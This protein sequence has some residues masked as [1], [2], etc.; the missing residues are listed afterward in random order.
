MGC[1]WP[2]LISGL[3]LDPVTASKHSRISL[4]IHQQ[5]SSR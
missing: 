4:R 1:W 2:A 5:Q 3:R